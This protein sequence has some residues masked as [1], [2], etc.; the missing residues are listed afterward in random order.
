MC[1]TNKTLHLIYDVRALPPNS[2]FLLYRL[3][4]YLFHLLS[5]TSLWLR[6]LRNVLT[7]LKTKTSSEPGGFNEGKAI[8]IQG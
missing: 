4:I 2:E 6:K 1:T 3:L 7:Q 8:I 5:S